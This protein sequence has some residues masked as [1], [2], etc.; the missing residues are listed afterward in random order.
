MRGATHDI[1]DGHRGEILRPKLRL[2]GEIFEIRVIRGQKRKGHAL[3]LQFNF[4]WLFRNSFS[5]ESF[6]FHFPIMIFICG[7]CVICGDFSTFVS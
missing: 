4:Q 5:N 1:S 3:S 7:I 2:K 6:A